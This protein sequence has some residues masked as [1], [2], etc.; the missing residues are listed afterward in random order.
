MKLEDDRLTFE[1]TGRES[2]CL[3]DC[4]SC[5]PDEPGIV[6]YGSDG[7]ITGFINPPLTPA[8]R[9]EIADWMIDRWQKWAE[10]LS[11]LNL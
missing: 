11:D 6:F 8:E 4:F 7:G 9:K 3:S 10:N 5:H 1:T 2:S